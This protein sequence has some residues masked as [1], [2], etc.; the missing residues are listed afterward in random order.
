MAAHVPQCP[1]VVRLSQLA[2]WHRWQALLPAL[3]WLLLLAALPWWLGLPL[4]LIAVAALLWRGAAPVLSTGLLRRALRWGLPGLLLALLRSFG[5][6][7]LGWLCASLSALVGFS[8]LMLLE[9]WLDRAQ[10]PRPAPA[11]SESDWPTLALAPVGPE[12]AII[13]LQPPAWRALAG[14]LADPLGG[15]LQWRDGAA[16]LADGSRQDGV[17]AQADFSADGRWLALPLAAR[18]GVLLLDRRR[19]RRHRLRGWQLAGW[20]QSQPWLCR[21]EEHAP[22]PIAHVLGN[23]EN[24]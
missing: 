12:A 19:G 22:L 3:A 15:E 21:D 14:G 16:R 13:E 18:R 10:P 11:V 17:E 8:L 4:L 23:D 9:G 20:H 6:G 5:G 2:A 1:R 7:A 24:D